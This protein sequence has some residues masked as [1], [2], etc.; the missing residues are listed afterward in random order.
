MRP[1]AKSAKWQVRSTESSHIVN[2]AIR[3]SRKAVKTE[4]DIS[5][6]FCNSLH[7][8]KK[9]DNYKNVELCIDGWNIKS[10]ESFL[11]GET[12]WEDTLGEDM[13]KISHINFKKHLGQIISSD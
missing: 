4:T 12:E 8:G 7:V 13:N 6:W 9:H 10:V 3:L 2:T 5:E 11:T 1:I